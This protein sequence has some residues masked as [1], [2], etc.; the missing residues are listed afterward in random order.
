MKKTERKRFSLSPFQ[1]IILGFAGV[2]LVGA[3]LLSLP[4]A[5]RSGEAT[6][7]GEAV[8]TSTSAACVTGLVVHDTATYWSP[9]GQAVILILIQ[10]G[11]LG[12]VTVA[13]SLTVMA[14][15]K[16]SLLQR[17]TMQEAMSTHKI[18]GV[19]KF[20]GFVV[21][22]TFIVEAIG[23]V[24]LAPVFIKDYGARGIWKAVFHSVS[25]FCN[26]GFDIMGE[27]G[28]P[29]RSLTPYASSGYVGAVIMILIVVGGIGF[30]TWRDVAEHKFRLKK[31][32]MQSKVVLMTSALLIILPAI[33]L[34]FAEYGGLPAGERV[35]T[36]LFQSVTTRTAGFNTADLTTLT[37]ASRLMMIA[38]MLVGGSPGSTA[39]GMKTTTLAVLVSS[40]FAVFRRRNDASFF[41]RRITETV[42][43]NA[44]AVFVMYAVLFLAGGAA[45]SAVEGLPIGVCL[46]ETAS[47]VGT[48]GLT[49]G[50]TPSLGAAS[51]AILILLMF[52]GRVGALTMV[53][54]AL[55]GSKVP[56]RYPVED[57][58]VG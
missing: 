4:F 12:V 34:F 9:F 8:F 32:S 24:A 36:S 54:A 53:Y 43:K 58:T 5:S 42:V 22:A 51:R 39:G 17:S 20:S 45:I 56:S 25:A 33:Y 46:F 30:L 2:I 57:I 40:A 19:V 13:S 38:L 35:V 48:V 21:K 28:A 15:K 6:P 18:G 55:S 31:Y 50:V 47:A 7:F 11:G 3:V 16:V 10:I 23:A 29:Y 37:G 1:L 27:E 44:A 14:G 26:A 41:G 49:L 52:L